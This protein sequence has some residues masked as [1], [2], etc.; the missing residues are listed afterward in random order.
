LL[1]RFYG[2]EEIAVFY[3]DGEYTKEWC[4]FKSN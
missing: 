1:L 4:G 3:V 2:K